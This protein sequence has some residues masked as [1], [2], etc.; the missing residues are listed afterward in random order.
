[1][2]NPEVCLCRLTRKSVPSD[3]TLLVAFRDGR[4]RRAPG[5]ADVVRRRVRRREGVAAAARTY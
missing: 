1:M 4:A 2:R 5:G 3:V